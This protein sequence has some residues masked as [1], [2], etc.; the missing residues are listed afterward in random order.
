MLGHS[1][2]KHALPNTPKVIAKWLRAQQLRKSWGYPIYLEVM[3]QAN[4]QQWRAAAEAVPLVPT[5]MLLF[6]VSANQLATD[7]AGSVIKALTSA[8]DE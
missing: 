1:Y 5:E 4:D 7:L 2:G 8:A 3:R 6:R